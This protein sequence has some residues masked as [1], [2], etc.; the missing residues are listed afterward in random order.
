MCS[1]STDADDSEEEMKLLLQLLLEEAVRD[2]EV[3]D[4]ALEVVSAY[5]S[6]CCD[7]LFKRLTFAFPCPCVVGMGGGGV[8][9]GQAWVKERGSCACTNKGKRK[10]RELR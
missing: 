1:F 5:S 8:G 9:G 4:L 7:S 3:T 6:Q 10:S 2:R